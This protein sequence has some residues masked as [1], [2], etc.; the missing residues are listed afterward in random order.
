[1]ICSISWPPC[2]II[3]TSPL[4]WFFFFPSAFCSASFSIYLAITWKSSISEI[5]KSDNVNFSTLN[6]SVLLSYLCFHIIK[7]SILWTIPHFPISQSL[8][9]LWSIISII[10]CHRPQVSCSLYI[11]PIYLN[12]L[13]LIEFKYLSTVS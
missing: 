10:F 8:P 11:H 3:H 2:F 12:T 4:F 1:M 5:T 6:T 9:Y 7:I 13:Y